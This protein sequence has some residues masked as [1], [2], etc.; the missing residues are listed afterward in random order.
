V[1]LFSSRTVSGFLR[2]H[3]DHDTEVSPMTRITAVL[4]FLAMALLGPL[5]C[6]DAKTSPVGAGSGGRI[7]GSDGGAGSPSGGAGGSMTFASTPG[8]DA[9][10][11]FITTCQSQADDDND[12]DGYSVTQGDCNDC[13]PNIN[14]GAYDVAG[15]SVDE[16][17]NGKA[18]DEPTGC[19]M[20]PASPATDAIEGAQSLGLCRVA[21]AT[22]TGKQRTWGVVSA[23]WVFPDGTGTSLDPATYAWPDPSIY[24]GACVA[25]GGGK[26]NPPHSLS[27]HVLTAFGPNV[28]PLDGKTMVALSSGVAEP[29]KI[30]ESPSGAA[31]CTRSRTPA[32]FPISSKMACPGQQIAAD[33]NANDGIALELEI[34][35][36][37]N[38]FGFSFDF[39]FYTYEF[40]EFVCT[41]FNDFFVA[42]LYSSHPST[43]ANKNI[44]FDKQGNPVSVNNAFVEVCTA[45]EAGE[46]MFACPLGRKELQGTGFDDPDNSAATSWL[47]TNAKI[48]PGETFKIRFAVWDMGDEVLDSTVLLDRFVWVLEEGKATISTERSPVIY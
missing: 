22:A 9:S 39:D 45:G 42:L 25:G 11:D 2:I 23:K 12:H 40:P 33:D 26:G 37:S 31:M 30:D 18:D 24:L 48:V 13:D 15:N 19:D 27:H 41:E 36:P 10:R 3:I 46:K 7:N 1:P 44:S 34:R 4:S 43:P 21:S 8:P 20:G 14:P 32:G 35:A 29:G 5:G 47:R 6:L 28:S 16:D 17:C 38:A